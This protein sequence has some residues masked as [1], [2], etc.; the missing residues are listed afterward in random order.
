M[1]LQAYLAFVA[2]CIA[3]ALLPG[4]IV[5]MVIANGLRYG[6]RAALTNVLGAQVGLAI[7]IGTVAVGLTSLMATMGYWFDWVRFAGAAYLVWLGIKLI[8]APVEGI[9]TDETPPPPRGG[10]FLQGFLVL[11]SNPKVLVFFGAFIPQFMDMSKPHIPQ[12]ALLGVTFMV[13]A[14]MTD[15]AYA[16][17]AG[18]ARKFFSKER[19]RLMSRISGGFM[20]G[21]GIWLALTRAR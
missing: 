5:T 13:T 20:I 9:S 17:L 18:R 14:V 12:V 16:L 19:T 15:G 21:G 1:S 2:A 6:T 4:P 8:R 3:L 10:F 11:L 7:V